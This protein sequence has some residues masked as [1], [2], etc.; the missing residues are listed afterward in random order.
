MILLRWLQKVT[1]FSRCTFDRRQA[2]KG[3]NSELCEPPLKFIQIKIVPCDF[4]MLV[5][6]S[7]I[8]AILLHIT[9]N[10]NEFLTRSLVGNGRGGATH[11]HAGSL[12]RVSFVSKRILICCLTTNFECPFCVVFYNEPILAIHVFVF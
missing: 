11:V 1:G 9:D 12:H 3:S 2:A 5:E 8:Q 10:F 4:H 7:F 6:K